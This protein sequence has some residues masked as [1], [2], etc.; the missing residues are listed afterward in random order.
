MVSFEVVAESE[1]ELVR[2][3]ACLSPLAGESALVTLQGHLGAGKT[4]LVRGLV[5]A[6]GFAGAVKSPTFSLVE[7]Y[8]LDRGTIYHFDL[9][10][11][12]DPEELEFMGMRDYLDQDSLCLVEWPEKADGF[13]PAGD[14][15]ITIE[16]VNKGRKVRLET[17]TDRGQV[18]FERLGLPDCWNS[19]WRHA[20]QAADLK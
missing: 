13:L 6:A 7:P 14:I 8:A 2:L 12:Q 1:P 11:L 19:I 5:Q 3:G 9:Y 16:I 20:D 4:T 15:N 17:I 10:R 18:L